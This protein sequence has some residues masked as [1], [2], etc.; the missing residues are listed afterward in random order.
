MATYL[1]HQLFMLPRDRIMPVVSAPLG[2]PFQGTGE[3]SR[4]GLTL[5]HPIPLLRAPPVVSK[6]KK[7]KCLRFY[8]WLLEPLRFSGIE[9]TREPYHTGLV[10]MQRQAIFRTPLRQS[11]PN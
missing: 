6:A 7:L 3:P 1:G 11:C 5:D 2:N 8:L 4:R 10:G 9:G